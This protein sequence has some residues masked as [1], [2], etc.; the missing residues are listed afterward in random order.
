MA[1]P[2]FFTMLPFLVQ[3][4]YDSGSSDKKLPN[5]LRIRELYWNQSVITSTTEADIQGFALHFRLV[6][7]NTFP[8]PQSIPLLRPF[9]DR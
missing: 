6:P 1:F 7:W 9:S 4:K 2:P 8:L 5:T 3:K